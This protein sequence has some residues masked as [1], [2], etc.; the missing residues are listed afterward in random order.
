MQYEINGCIK[1]VEEDVFAHGCKPRTERDFLVEVRLRADSV[2]EL[3]K[4]LNDFLGNDDP[5]A[6]EL[7]ACEE[8]GRIDVQMLENDNEY[9][10]TGRQIAAWKEGKERLWLATYSM[11]VEAVDRRNVE[12][13]PL[14]MKE[15]LA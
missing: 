7:D 12:L 4:K 15:A 1:S 6:V 8:P 10:A 2:E 13:R 5:S 11:K 14:V 3:I 9:A